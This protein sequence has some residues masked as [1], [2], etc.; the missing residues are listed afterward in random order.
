M[1]FFTIKHLDKEPPVISG[2]S[3]DIT[4]N[5]DSGAAT[6]A[7]SWDNPTATDNG[8]GNPSVTSDYASGHSFSIGVT[9]VTCSTQDTSGNLATSSFSVTIN[10]MNRG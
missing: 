8:G 6:A 4:Q 9:A 5:T 7:V 2:C 10:G 1:I 3:E